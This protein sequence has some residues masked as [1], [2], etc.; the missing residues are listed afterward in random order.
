MCGRTMFSYRVLHSSLLEQLNIDMS[1]LKLRFIVNILADMKVC[2]FEELGD[3]IFEFEVC[4]NAEKSNVELTSTYKWL[5]KQ[6][7]AQ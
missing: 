3:D 1:C 6:C 4:K 2:E 7:Q 5:Q